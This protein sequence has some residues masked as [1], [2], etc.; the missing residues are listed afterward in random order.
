[1]ETED[2]NSQTDFGILNTRKFGINIHNLK[3]IQKKEYLI[4][5]NYFAM[6]TES[7]NIKHLEHKLK[8]LKLLLNIVINYRVIFLIKKREVIAKKC[9]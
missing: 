6:K 7:N 3:K 2:K 5:K 8:I 1:M 4:S 9:Y